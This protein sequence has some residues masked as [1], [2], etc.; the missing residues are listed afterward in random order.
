MRIKVGIKFAPANVSK[1]VLIFSLIYCTEHINL[2]PRNV[3]KS[4]IL[5]IQ[6]Q[7]GLKFIEKRRTKCQRSGD[8]THKRS[9][10]PSCRLWAAHFQAWI[11]IA[12][13][14]FIE[15]IAWLLGSASYLISGTQFGCAPLGRACA[16]LSRG[17]IVFHFMQSKRIQYLF[18]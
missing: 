13:S 3:P 15:V 14:H 4:S 6:A 11:T 12:R 8:S 2:N 16:E 10:L 17:W 9:K 5:S 7:S 18:I 1:N